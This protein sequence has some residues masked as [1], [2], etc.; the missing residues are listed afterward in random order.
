MVLL[1]LAVLNVL[2]PLIVKIVRMIK[3]NAKFAK[4]VSSLLLMHVL[5]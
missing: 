4:L 3:P 2:M 1:L 5:P